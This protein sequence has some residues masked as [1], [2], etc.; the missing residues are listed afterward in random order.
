MPIEYRRALAFEYRTNGRH[1]EFKEFDIQMIGIQIPTVFQH[2]CS[3]P[4]AFNV[5]LVRSQVLDASNQ[6]LGDH[7]IM[8]QKIWR[9]S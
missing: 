7:K 8:G 1:F 2:L 5:S 3:L 9:G 6:L 4:G